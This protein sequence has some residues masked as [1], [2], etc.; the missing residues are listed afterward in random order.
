MYLGVI[1][2]PAPTREL[3]AAPLHPY[4]RGADRARSR[5]PTAPASLPEALPGE[6]PDPAQPP[7]G[8]RFHPRCP[9]AFDLCRTEVP[10]PVVVGADHSAVCLA[11][12]RGHGGRHGRAADGLATASFLAR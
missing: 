7:S 9:V 3:W 6:V 12:G 11:R 5:T 4:T 8:C 10:E 2:E 1:V